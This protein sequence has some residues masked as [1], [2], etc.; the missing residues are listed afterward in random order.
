MRSSITK[1][2]IVISGH[3][4]SVSLEEPFWIGLKEIAKRHNTTMSRIVAQIELTRQYGNLSSAIRL[5]VLEQ[6]RHQLAPG[7]RLQDAEGVAAE[8][9]R[10]SFV[11]REAAGLAGIC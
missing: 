6:S 8:R 3:K 11:R 1:R 7:E 5:F 4:T 10:N 9:L 2:S